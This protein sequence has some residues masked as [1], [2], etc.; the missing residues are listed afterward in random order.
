VANV[1]SEV[2]KA[3]KEANVKQWMVAERYG[4]HEGNFSRLLR[5]ELPEDEK[6]KIL[7]II[8]ELKA[9]KGA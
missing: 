1:N 9:Q 5:H 3:I 4:L 6:E 8:E 7:G 2:K